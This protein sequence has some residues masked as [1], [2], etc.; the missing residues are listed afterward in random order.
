MATN[1]SLNRLAR[2]VPLAVGFA[3]AAF[4]VTGWFASA[5]ACVLPC[6]VAG[7]AAWVSGI[8]WLVLPRSTAPGRRTIVAIL[9]FAVGTG[10]ATIWTQAC[11]P[12]WWG[13]PT[14]SW[15][16]LALC[17]LVDY[18]SGAAIAAVLLSGP[19]R[20][21]LRYTAVAMSSALAGAGLGGAFAASI[22]GHSVLAEGAGF[23]VGAF[24]GVTVGLLAYAFRALWPEVRLWHGHVRQVSR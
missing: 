11:A 4:A 16:A 3:L 14:V 9:V 13:L 19:G 5:R 12:L 2:A 15:L 22:S 23:L 8:V 18:L 1:L 20:T 21:L 17:A 7:R 6:S 10:L 24:A